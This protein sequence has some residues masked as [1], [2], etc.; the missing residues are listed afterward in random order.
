MAEQGRTKR[1]RV[2]VAVWSAT[3]LVAAL[4][5]AGI[6]YE[7][8]PEIEVLC[9]T[10]SFALE[11]GAMD[12][13]REQL[14]RAREQDADF[15]GV[16]LL[17]ARLAFLEEDLPRGEAHL[18]RVLEVEPDNG[19]AHLYYGWS[20][21][22]RGAWDVAL[23]HYEAGGPLLQQTGRVDLIAEYRIRLGMLLLGAGRA[24]EALEIGEL[25]V[26]EGSRSSAGHLISAYSHLALGADTKF[27]H[28]LGRAY[29]SDPLEPLFR[30]D[31]GPLSRAFPWFP[32]P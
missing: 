7:A 20:A 26:A 30:Q 25:L 16:Q 17:E 3:A 5:V 13:A 31:C 22:E 21:Y 11:I 6:T 27:G 10:A 32:A 1:D 15:P 24:R 23:H 19:E 12:F 8:E 18:D 4:G 9:G 14:D 28:E 29:S 2:R